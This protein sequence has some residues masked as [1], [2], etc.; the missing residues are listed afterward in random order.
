MIEIKISGGVGNQLF[1][2]A[3]GYAMSKKYNHKLVLDK[4][5]FDFDKSRTYELNQF[6]LSETE[7]ISYM[8][9][10]SP[11]GGLR[12]VQIL[13]RIGRK[14]NKLKHYQIFQEHDGMSPSLKE[15]NFYFRGFW[16]N[17]NYF[18]EYREELLSQLQPNWKLSG[19]YY[20]WLE[21]I[22]RG[23]SVSIHIRRTD[24]IKYRATVG[25][26]YYHI[27]IQKISELVNVDT[28]YV[29]TDDVQWVTEYFNTKIGLTNV[30]IVSEQ[31]EMSDLEELMLMKNCRHHIIA[32]SSFSWWGA[33]MGENVDKVVI[34]PKWKMWDERFYPDDWILIK[35]KAEKQDNEKRNRTITIKEKLTSW[36]KEIGYL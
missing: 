12:Y 5:F 10:L 30:K 15:G 25:T 27:A 1:Q 36:I 23:I 2:Y 28:F 18:K 9:G 4:S 26:E 6:K 21:E 20:E 7:A 34:A 16:Q 11:K 13:V 19:T 17:E 22:Q 14:R 24:Y 35:L 33:W 29:F 3:F 31:N 8:D 32:N